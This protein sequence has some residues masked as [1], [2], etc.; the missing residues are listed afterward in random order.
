[1]VDFVLAVACA[2]V[3]A[4]LGPFL[5][6]ASR[7][8]HERY[9]VWSDVAGGELPAGR[10]AIWFGVG[11]GALFGLAALRWGATG[12]LLPHLA[13]FAVLVL[14]TAIDLE[15]LLIPNRLVFPSVVVAVPLIV[16]VSVLD[17]Q[18]RSVGFALVG[19]LAYF[20][21]LLITHLVSPKG[22]GFGDVKLA[23]LLGLFIGW[24]A[25]GYSAALFLV[26]VG[27]MVACLLGS[28]IGIALLISR[29]RGVQYPFGPWLAL[30]TV[31]VLLTAPLLPSR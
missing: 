5:A 24:T 7:V 4:L 23:L 25:S 30:G 18:T 2:A 28:V 3:G 15:H 26:L 17:G 16:A 9:P 13:L 21:G 14:V 12:R 20:G 29:G 27:L 8:L 6:R 31:V 10:R 22:M 19:G 1:V 11:C